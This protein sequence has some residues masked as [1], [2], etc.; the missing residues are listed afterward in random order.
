MVEQT[1]STE[2]FQIQIL[3]EHTATTPQKMVMVEQTTSKG[4][5]QIQTLQE[6]I[7]TTLHQM[8]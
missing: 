7:L 6:H 2:M 5:F 8:Q 4:V 3:T 1:S